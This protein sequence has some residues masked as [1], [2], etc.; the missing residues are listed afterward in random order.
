MDEV[1]NWLTPELTWFLLGV[2]LFLLELAVPGLVLFFFGIAAWIVSIITL[3]FDI[4]TSSQITIF[5]GISVILIFTLREKLKQ[6][7]Q[8]DTTQSELHELRSDFIGKKVTVTERI[9]VNSRGKVE[10][11]GTNWYAES[12]EDI[13][14]GEIVEIIEKDNLTFK[15]KK[16]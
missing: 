1:L 11:N 6:Y 12:I 5:I 16:L 10:L 13:E 15:V 7:F 2:I 8:G 9:K 3:M 14:V 4:N